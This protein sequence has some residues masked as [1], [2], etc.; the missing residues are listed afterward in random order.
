MAL[1][2]AFIIAHNRAQCY[3]FVLRPIN[4]PFTQPSEN[5]A[6]YWRHHRSAIFQYR[7]DAS[8]VKNG[9]SPTSAAYLGFRRFSCEVSRRGS[10]SKIFNLHNIDT[11]RML[12]VR[13]HMLCTHDGT[14][15][16]SVSIVVHTEPM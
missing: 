16:F 5:G 13:K 7:Y 3:I 10:I 14:A 15:T 4:E 11:G 2:L 8:I 1:S 12:Q 9:A 6:H